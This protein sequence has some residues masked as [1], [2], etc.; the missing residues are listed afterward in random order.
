[1]L[2][3][4]GLIDDV[5]PCY[6]PAKPRPVYKSHDVQAYWDVPV[7]ADQEEARCNRFDVRIVDHKTKRVIT[8]E[9]SCP[10]VKNREKKSILTLLKNNLSHL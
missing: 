6:S 7:F 3:D 10:W 9:M 8:V 2:H 1:M 5:P 4:L